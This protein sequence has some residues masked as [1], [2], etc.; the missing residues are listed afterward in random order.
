[1]KPRVLA[2]R[3]WAEGEIAK[4]KDRLCVCFSLPGDCKLSTWASVEL[5]LAMR[6]GWSVSSFLFLFAISIIMADRYME[7]N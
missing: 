7:L 5:G 6:M 4:E 3:A 1:M 2:F